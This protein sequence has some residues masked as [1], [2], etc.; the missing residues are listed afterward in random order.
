MLGKIPDSPAW[1]QIALL[2]VLAVMAV[3]GL[4]LTTRR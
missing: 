2:V 1:A 3:A 4:Y